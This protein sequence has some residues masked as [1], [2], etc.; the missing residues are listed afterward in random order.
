MR[1]SFQ[2]REQAFEA[3]YA[4]DEEFRFRVTAR[5]DKLFAPPMMVV[6]SFS[7]SA[8]GAAIAASTPRAINEGVCQFGKRLGQLRG[9]A[10]G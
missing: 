10:A 2:D 8:R 1:T 5:R 3:N 4:H 9:G 6:S 7:I